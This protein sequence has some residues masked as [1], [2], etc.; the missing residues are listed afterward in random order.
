MKKA[1][2]AMLLALALFTTGCRSHTEYG[3]CIG[4][5][6]EPEPELVYRVD[7]RNAVLGI[8]FFET[9]VVPVIWLADEFKCPIA[10]KTPPAEK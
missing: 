7:V 6:D 9:I 3:E 4:V 1:I 8:L 5:G 2:V 10:R